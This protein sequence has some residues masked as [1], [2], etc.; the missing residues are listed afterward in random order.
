MLYSNKTRSLLS[1]VIL[2]GTLGLG[3]ARA[4]ALEGILLEVPQ[5]QDPYCH[6]KFPAIEERT[7]GSKHPV[8]KDSGSGDVI[9]FYGPCDYDPLG[10]EE[11]QKQILDHEMRDSTEFSE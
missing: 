4:W 2:A 5:Q 6:L 7:L 11:V 9:D 1:V 3:A 8:L 10:A